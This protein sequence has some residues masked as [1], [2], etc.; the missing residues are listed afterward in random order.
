ME[1]DEIEAYMID[2]EKEITRLVKVNSELLI[3]VKELEGLACDMLNVI[4]S[5]I[6]EAFG[7]D[8]RMDKLFD[9]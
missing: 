7:F 8:D 9:C 4:P 6:V 2:Q 3:K 5:T 1:L